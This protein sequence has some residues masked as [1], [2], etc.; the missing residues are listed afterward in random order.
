VALR[1]LSQ[2]THYSPDGTRSTQPRNS[3]ALV[4]H[5]L[6]V[7]CQLDTPLQT[8]CPIP[9][10]AEGGKIEVKE[11]F[12]DSMSVKSVSSDVSLTLLRVG[13]TEGNDEKEEITLKPMELSTV[14]LHL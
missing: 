13:E 4:L 9:P 6:G 5:R 14:M 3:A 1:T 8:H 12:Q 11:L 2:P 7:E 10:G